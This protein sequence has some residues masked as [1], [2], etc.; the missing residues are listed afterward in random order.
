M[1]EPAVIDTPAALGLAA[2][3]ARKRLGLT[4]PQLA[5]AAGVGI[6]GGLIAAGVVTLVGAALFGV[7]AVLPRRSHTPARMETAALTPA[8]RP[9]RATA[10][11][12]PDAGADG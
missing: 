6:P 7:S 10:E 1:S 11:P 9:T 8:E 5:L 3:T 12:A 4:Q 2:R